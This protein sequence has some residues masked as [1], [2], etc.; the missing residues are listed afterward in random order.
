MPWLEITAFF[1]LGGLLVLGVAGT[2]IAD[3][4][5]DDHVVAG[6]LTAGFVA[7]TLIADTRVGATF[8]SV[9]AVGEA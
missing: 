8:Q 4:H 5:V 3:S 2:P 1:P 6:V 9:F 7:G